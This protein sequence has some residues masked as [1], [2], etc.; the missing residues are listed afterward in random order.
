MSRSAKQAVLG[1]GA[2]TIVLISIVVVASMG[3][4]ARGLRADVLSQR[5]SAPGEQIPVSVAVRDTKG[6]VRSVVVDFGD[7]S[8]SGATIDASRPCVAPVAETFDF[9]HRYDDFDSTFTIRATVVTGGCGAR[10]ET[11][12]AIR[13]I[14]VKAIS[15]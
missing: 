13:T 3:G 8:S 15:G 4:G 14:R 12:E 6:M 7:D 11:V 2:L 10:T 5:R 1:L 9:T